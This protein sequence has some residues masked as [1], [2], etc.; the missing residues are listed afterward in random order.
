LHAGQ[1]RYHVSGI[2]VRSFSLIQ[3]VVLVDID[4]K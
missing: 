1:L 4:S 3:S 2:R